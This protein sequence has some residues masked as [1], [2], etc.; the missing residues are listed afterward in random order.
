MFGTQISMLK[1]DRVALEPIT[2][3]L[4]LVDQYKLSFLHK[5]QLQFHPSLISCS[6]KLYDAT[7]A[8]FQAQD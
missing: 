5:I 2:L 1:L 6:K 4:L 8:F 7:V 3:L